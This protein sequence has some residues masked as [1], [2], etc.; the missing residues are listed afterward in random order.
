MQTAAETFRK[1]LKSFRSACWDK[2]AYRMMK[3][4]Y[5]N[6]IDLVSFHL[7]LEIGGRQMKP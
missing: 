2:G 4:A 6:P 1:I 5:K 7:A 3:W